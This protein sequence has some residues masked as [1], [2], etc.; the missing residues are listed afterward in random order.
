MKKILLFLLLTVQAFGVTQE[1]E[2]IAITILA[3][4]RSEGPDGMWAVAAVINQRM[5]DR[6]LSAKEVCLQKYQFSCWNG[7]KVSDLKHLLKIPQAKTAL[8]LAENIHQIDRSK[9]KFANHYYADYIKA[10]Y[11][12]KGKKPT[13]KIGKHIFY[14]L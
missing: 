6:N 13:V 10:P 8:Y 14:K 3:E 11:W 9:T 2:I 12:A 4:A 5:L 7:K 1:Q